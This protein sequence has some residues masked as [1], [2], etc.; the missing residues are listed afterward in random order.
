MSTAASTST[1]I[2]PTIFLMTMASTTATTAMPMSTQ[3]VVL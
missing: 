2:L 1:M 3:G